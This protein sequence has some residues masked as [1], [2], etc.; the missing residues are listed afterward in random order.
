MQHTN[1]RPTPRRLRHPW[2]LASAAAVLCLA[3]VLIG[4]DTISDFAS[5]LVHGTTST[6]VSASPEAKV[7]AMP[8]RVCANGS[9]LGGAPRSAPAHA[10]TVPAGDNSSLDFGQAGATYWFAP[11]VHTLGGDE[12]KQIIPGQGATF[13]GAPGAVLDG[14]HHNDYAFGGY[15]SH[16]TV[17]Y[18]T[19]RNFGTWGDN[20]GQG[21]VNHNS[22]PYW[23]VDH[24]TVTDNAGAGV[25]VG[26]HDLLS[27]NCLTDNQEYG[28]DAY[29]PGNVSAIT[30][31]HNEISG[32]DTY[33]WEAHQQ[34]CGCTGGGK[35]WDVDGAVVTN[36]LVLDNLS[37]GLW[38]DTN[39]RGFQ[40][41]GNYISGN[42]SDGLI[43]EISYNAEIAGNTFVR[44]GIAEGPKNP[45]FPTSA[46]YISESG[47]DA[48]VAGRF[49]G[50]LRIT[51]NTFAD[52]WGGVVL[53]ENS[54]RFCNSPANT[55]SGYCTLVE[56][57]NVTLRS[58][59][60]GDIA[61]QPYY[62]D[63]RWKTQNV[64]VDHNVFDFWPDA[65]GKTC[66]V[67]AACGFQGLFSEYGTYPSWS[68]YQATAV[69]KHI[70]FGQENRFFAN[71][72]NGPWQFMIYQQ[73]NV[74]SWTT[75]RAQPYSQD[76][77]STMNDENPYRG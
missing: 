50:E 51:K 33:N 37:V 73:G 31:D 28:F 64:S 48:R 44:N 8:Q 54:N 6:A 49:R 66:T 62:S 32:N 23:T 60:A 45:G 75:W 13:V 36:N 43:Y 77:Q 24:S 26:S 58:C 61:K 72:Y 22:A 21:V 69:E 10:V 11:G 67:E 52:N 35:F 3:A 20:Q 15:A 1:R 25:M 2:R 59:T 12:F 63:C 40:I 17:S 55:S 14:E 19:I 71:I 27:Y 76:K 57:D 30:I 41:T 46:I 56:P 7:P 9:V 4:S 74:V 16:V 42:Y 53:W 29:A 34:G 38:A 18:L 70:T 68:P 39:N 47:G 65:V 5:G